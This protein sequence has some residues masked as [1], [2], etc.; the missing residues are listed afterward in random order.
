MLVEKILIANRG[1]IAC[2]IIRTIKKMGYTSVAVFSDADQNAL[3]VQEADEAIYIG[4]SEPAQSYLNIDSIIQAAKLIQADAIHPGYGFLSENA[5]F[6]QR[7]NQE[8]LIFIGPTPDAINLMGSKSKSKDAMIA[9]QVPCIPGYQGSD[10]SDQ[11]FIEEAHKMGFP[12]MVKAAAGGGGRGMRKVN[13]ANNLLEALQSARSEAQTGFGNPEL[14]LEKAIENGRH[15]EIQILADTFGHCI[16]LGERDCSLQR[17]HQKVIEEAPSP[18]NRASLR[19]EMGA[20]AVAAAESCH[21]VGA[22]TV[23]FLVDDDL[24]FYFLEM[25]TRIQVEHPVTELVT[26]VDLIEQQIRVAIGEPL[27]L[28]QKDIKIKGHAIEARLYAEDPNQN[29]MPQAGD[30]QLFQTPT[31]EGIRCDT[32]IAQGLTVSTFYDPMIAKIIAYGET[33]AQALRRLTNALR[34]THLCGIKTNRDFLIQL[35]DADYVREGQFDTSTLQSEAIIQD[36]LEQDVGFEKLSV[37]AALLMCPAVKNKRC[38]PSKHASQLIPPQRQLLQMNEKI[39]ALTLNII[40]S[41]LDCI[42]CTLQIHQDSAPNTSHTG[43]TPTNAQSPLLYK[44]EIQIWNINNTQIEVTFESCRT[45]YYY[46]QNDLDIW[47]SNR[48]FSGLV[49]RYTYQEHGEGKTDGKLYAPMDG[50]ILT[51]NATV[52]ADVQKDQTLAV[53]DAMKIEHPL[54]APFDGVVESINAQQNQQVKNKQL[55]ISLAKKEVIFQN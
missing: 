42:H 50:R 31:S 52:G 39:Y 7:C 16:H 28:Q 34:N 44:G 22:G 14:I 12:V 27:S 38:K 55:I 24:S 32:G 29:Y 21:Y 49:S 54:K 13:S 1:E 35:L 26:G 47:V 8:K 15:I 41:S 46:T 17:R 11:K 53:L 51:I 43:L 18:L 5:E 40:N 48:H 30:I 3:H 4:S 36:L 37:A 19:D 9:A 10:Q 2:R 33:R 6:A 45:S 20:A 23:E 25:N